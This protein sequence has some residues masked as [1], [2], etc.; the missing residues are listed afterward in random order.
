MAILTV[1]H[2]S[3]IL[4]G[5]EELR[6]VSRGRVVILTWVPTDSIFW[7]T[8]YIPEVLDTDQSKFPMLHE[9]EHVVG[10]TSD[11]LPRRSFRVKPTKPIALVAQSLA[12]YFRLLSCGL[13]ASW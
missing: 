2:W 3:N 12:F 10:Q 5:L 11:P 6:R 1:H 7:L 8:D 13:D 4:Q 9:Y